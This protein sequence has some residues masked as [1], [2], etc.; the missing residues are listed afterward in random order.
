MFC[1]RR[2]QQAQW[3]WRPHRQILRVHRRTRRHRILMENRRLPQSPAEMYVPNNQVCGNHWD[4]LQTLPDD[5][6]N[7]MKS[8]RL[9]D[10]TLNVVW[11]S[12]GTYYLMNNLMFMTCHSARQPGRII[13]PLNLLP[14]TLLR[15]CEAYLTIY[16]PDATR[17]LSPAASTGGKT[18]PYQC[19]DL[20]HF[21]DA[22]HGDEVSHSSQKLRE[23]VAKDVVSSL[24]APST[25]PLPLHMDPTN[26]HVMFLQQEVIFTNWWCQ[27]VPKKPVGIT[28]RFLMSFGGDADPAPMKYP[29][30]HDVTTPIVHDLFALVVRHVGARITQSSDLYIT[31]TERQ[32]LPVAEL[33]HILQLHARRKGVHE[34]FQAALPNGIA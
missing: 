10:V 29:F 15:S 3:T 30:L 26:V 19:T 31:C 1:F 17:C 33:E 20:E 27:T 34:C 9:Q 32:A 24:A 11:D 13:L 25:K 16:C 18:D 2:N 12:K 21:L 8:F 22:A 28:Q 23:K 5:F 14:M 6:S 7:M 4:T